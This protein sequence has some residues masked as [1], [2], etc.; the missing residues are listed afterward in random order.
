MNI[1]LLSFTAVVN[2][3]GGAAKVLCN[4]ANHFS[5]KNE[6]M[7]VC[8]DVEQG[9]PFYPINKRCKFLN[10][11]KTGNKV[12]IPIT[13][14]V[15]SEVFRIFNKLGCNIELPKKKY[16]REKILLDIR[17]CLQV[18]RPNVAIC[19]DFQAL[20]SLEE[21]GY[22][23]SKS[24][25]MLHAN[26]K[27]TASLLD[28]RQKAVL[29][30]VK[31]FQVLL[32]SDKK[33]FEHLG[34]TNVVCIGNIVPQYPKMGT[35]S[36]KNIISNISRLEKHKGQDKLILAFARI[37]SKYP[38]WSVEIWGGDDDKG[39]YTAYLNRLIKKNGLESQVKLKGKTDCVYNVLTRSAFFVFPSEQ[40]GFGLSLTEAMSA[41][42]P[43]IGYQDSPG[44]NELIQNEY[45]GFLC[46]VGN[47]DL[48]KKIELLI[49]N[50]ELREKMGENAQ[51]SIKQYDGNII[52]G[53]W[54]K[55]I[56]KIY[57]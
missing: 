28:N 9:V 16:Q 56:Q 32:P 12:H 50:V 40:E 19:Y 18:F 36:S 23:M 3:A 46:H 52:W 20:L 55:L 38:D 30:K 11:N 14:K 53:K 22:D 15:L 44:I 39:K 48:S 13:I 54:D 35:H 37:A 41:G 1:L 26:G 24:V 6:V 34:Y 43:T 29:H 33:L 49:N 2:N 47:D 17:K 4:M 21:T 5:E 25:F 42:L 51:Q 57:P 7:V 10:F 31:Y 27:I 8:N 45:N